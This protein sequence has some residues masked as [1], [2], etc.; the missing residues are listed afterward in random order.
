M[1][2]EAENAGVPSFFFFFFFSLSLSTGEVKLTDFGLSRVIINRSLNDEEKSPQE[3]LMDC[4]VRNGSHFSNFLER[5]SP[6]SDVS[7]SGHG[8]VSAMVVVGEKRFFFV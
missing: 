7:G 5:E 6:L 4:S 3:D 1:V 8:S 2:P